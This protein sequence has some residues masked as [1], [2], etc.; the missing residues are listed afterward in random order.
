MSALPRQA[1][2]ADHVRSISSCSTCTS[3]VKISSDSGYWN[4]CL[5]HR[6]RERLRSIV[7]STS[8]CVCVCLSVCPREYLR[9][10]THDLYQI[11]VHVVHGRGSRL[12]RR[13]CDTLRTSS[14]VDNI[15]FFSI[16]GRIAV[17]ISLRRTNFAFIAQMRP[18]ATDVARSVIRLSAACVSVCWAHG[19][20]VQ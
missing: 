3:F 8:V 2:M 12:P 13:R 18:I 1:V 11:F 10:H 17:W 19:W 7:M 4:S 6:L 5:L 16:M 15:M 14:F 20:A 9:N